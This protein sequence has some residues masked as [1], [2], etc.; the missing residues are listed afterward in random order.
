MNICVD[1]I[2]MHPY[3]W[4]FFDLECSIFTNMFMAEKSRQSVNNPNPACQCGVP[5]KMICVKKEGPNCGRYFYA[6]SANRN[7]QC[8]VC[9][10]LM[11]RYLI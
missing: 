3:E 1:M 7:Q 2:S 8:K 11:R 10:Y 5:S 9:L 4:Q 6:C